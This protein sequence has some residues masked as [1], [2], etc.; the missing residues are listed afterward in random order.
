[1][2]TIKSNEAAVS[3]ITENKLAE[4][5]RL[6]QLPSDHD[7]VRIS[8]HFASFSLLGMWRDQ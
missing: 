1:M 7:A 2:L 6:K 5:L 8:T 4:K 3:L